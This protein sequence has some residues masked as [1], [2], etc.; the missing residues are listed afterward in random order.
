M[1]TAENAENAE[2][3]SSAVIADSAVHFILMKMRCKT[4]NSAKDRI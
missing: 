2:M 4:P 3:Y 1:R